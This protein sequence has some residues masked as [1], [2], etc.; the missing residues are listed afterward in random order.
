MKYLVWLALFS[1]AS[2]SAFSDHH[3]LNLEAKQSRTELNIT[4]IQLGEDKC[5]HSRR[6][7]WRVRK[8]VRYLLLDL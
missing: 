5:R 8:G 2:T 3:E 1:L 7:D 6:R 4:S